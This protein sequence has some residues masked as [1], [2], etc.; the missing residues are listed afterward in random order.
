M[1]TAFPVRSTPTCSTVKPIFLHR[2]S[3]CKRA[4]NIG[5]QCLALRTMSLSKETSVACLLFKSTTS[6]WCICCISPSCWLWLS[7]I[8]CIFSWSSS[9]YCSWSVTS[10]HNFRLCCSTSFNFPLPKREPIFD[11]RAVLASVLAACSFSVL[12]SLLVC[13][14]SRSAPLPPHQITTVSCS[15]EVSPSLA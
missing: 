15:F 1:L 5:N 3:I 2:S 11:T 7:S 14:S 8:R 13:L 9:M 4:S 6:A 10:S 12:I